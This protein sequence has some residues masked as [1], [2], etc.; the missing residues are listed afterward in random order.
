[1][2]ATRRQGL[3]GLI[4][5][6]NGGM[7]VHLGVILVAVALVTSNAYTE[8]DRARVCRPGDEVAWGGHTFELVDVV[9][10]A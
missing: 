2:L 7:I 3:R 4:G 8:L 6:A 1:M 9:A 5:R 10:R